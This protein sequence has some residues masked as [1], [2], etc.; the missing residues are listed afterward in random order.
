M[1]WKRH[2]VTKELLKMLDN[3]RTGRLEELAHGHANGLEQ[4]YLEM[5]RLQGIEDALHFLVEDVKD[6]IVDDMEVEDGTNE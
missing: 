5:G 4:I 6:E 3:N 2:P 1:E